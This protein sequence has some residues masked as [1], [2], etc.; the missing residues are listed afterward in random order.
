VTVVRIVVG[1]KPRT[2]CGGILK[3]LQIFGFAMPKIFF[4][5]E[6]HHK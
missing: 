3:K 2:S 4:A 6:F 1:A 5:S